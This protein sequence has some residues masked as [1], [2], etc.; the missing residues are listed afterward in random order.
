VLD[1]LDK[2]APYERRQYAVGAAAHAILEALGKASAAA[3]RYL[4]T[5]EAEEVARETCRRLIAEGRDF[6][7]EREPPMPSAAVWAGRD[8][9]MAYQADSPMPPGYRFE[10][11]LAVN[12]AWQLVP[13]HPTAWLRCAVDQAGTVL[14]G[15]MDE[16]GG[17]VLVVKDYK[18]AWTAT[19]A[20]LATIQR[21]I[22]AV[23]A[24]T[25]WGDG[26]SALRLVVVNFRLRREFELSVYPE[27][28]DGAA[29]LARW[30]RDIEDEIAARSGNREAS[31]GACCMGCPFLWQCVPA[32]M[33]LRPVYGSAHADDQARAYAV[34]R[35][36]VKSLAGDSWDEQAPLRLATAEEPI[37][38]PGGVVGTVAKEERALVPDA[39]Q[40]LAAAWLRKAPA[41]T[42]A[43]AN[44]KLPGLLR[45]LDLSVTSAEK[46]LKHLYRGSKEARARRAELLEGLIGSRAVRRFGL[47]PKEESPDVPTRPS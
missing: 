25:A 19:E 41:E 7:G 40:Q 5:S 12:R 22:Q 14:P 2:G 13:F 36:A 37:K 26:H 24:W 20:E 30:R 33:Y 27:T 44:A 32:Q 17:P 1:F 38:V 29:V 46:L 31:P 9:A 28:P 39:P 42:L 23:L 10:Q 34:A 8:L 47:H 45:V 3:D 43:A 11:G 35:A 4:E 18:S 16:Q 6:E 21:K 15:V